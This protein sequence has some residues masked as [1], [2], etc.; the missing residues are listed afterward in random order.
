MSVAPGDRTH[1]PDSLR[2]IYNVINQQLIQLKQMT[3]VR[4]VS[5]GFWLV[6][7]TNW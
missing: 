3:P 1:I 5:Y 4:A 7:L 2:P 6:I